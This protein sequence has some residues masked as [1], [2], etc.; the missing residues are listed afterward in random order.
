MEPFVVQG[1]IDKKA[2]IGT[3][4]DFAKLPLRLNPTSFETD[5]FKQFKS[6]G[7]NRVSLGIQAFDERDLSVLE[8][9]N[10]LAV[11]L[12]RL[13]NQQAKFFLGTI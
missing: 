6:V 4:S 7:V 13:S 11:K 5:K 2:S 8:E 12:L 9:E 1:V 10:I 3:I